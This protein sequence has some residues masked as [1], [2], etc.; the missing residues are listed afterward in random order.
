MKH[1]VPFLALVLVVGYLT[2]I[3]QVSSQT[4]LI[5]KVWT[6]KTEYAVGELVRIYF[7]VNKD[8]YIRLVLIKPGSTPILAEGDVTGGVVYYV[9]GIAGCPVG[10]RTVKLYAWSASEGVVNTTSFRVRY[11]F[12]VEVSV[13]VFKNGLAQFNVV[14]EPQFTSWSTFYEVCYKEYS[15]QLHDDQIDLISGFTGISKNSITVIE[16]NYYSGGFYVKA[17]VDLSLSPY[18]NL[19]MAFYKFINPIAGDNE[20]ILNLFQVYVEEGISKVSPAPSS[21]QTYTV[22]WSGIDAKDANEFII[23]SFITVNVAI[24]GLPA[25]GEVKVVVE[26][27]SGKVAEQYVK[28]GETTVFKLAGGNTYTVKVP[29][30]VIIGDEY[31]LNQHNTKTVST[32]TS[33]VFKY[34]G[35]F[36]RFSIDC[37]YTVEIKVL[38]LKEKL[39]MTWWVVPNQNITVKVPE[40]VDYNNGTRLVFISW[41]DGYNKTFR[42]FYVTGPVKTGVKYVKQYYV[43]INDPVGKQVGITQGEGWYNEGS[44]ATLKVLNNTVYVSSLERYV[45]EE[46]SGDISSDSTKVTAKVDKP[47]TVTVE[48]KHQYKLIVET[49]YSKAILTPYSPDGWYDEGTTV[50]VKIE[51]TS[52]SDTPFTGFVFKEW[53]REDTG[54]TI[55]SAEITVKMD[56]PVKLKAVWERTYNITLIALVVAVA[57]VVPL[58]L[59]IWKRGGLAGI[60]EKVKRVKPPEVKPKV[61]PPTPPPTTP[62][63]EEKL[64][65]PPP[66]REKLP[67]TEQLLPPPPEKLPPPPETTPPPPKEVPPP[68]PKEEKIIQPPPEKLPPP[69]VE[70]KPVAPPPPT[71]IC[72][73]GG[74]D[75]QRGWPPPPSKDGIFS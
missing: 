34:I 74:S 50:T 36:Y 22:S 29:E 12:N 18:S 39:P 49:D 8:A 47:I 37:N 31:Y 75:S 9:E 2:W 46:W 72:A 3:P 1:A 55:E 33:I 66:P 11:A 64:P 23:S 4:P 6:T 51:E 59:F 16:K 32:S 42:W 65:P 58:T 38:S 63:L 43:T 21:L 17:G 67:P 70:V 56:K 48:W 71:N 25:S 20:K 68:P 52:I 15:S 35:P 5:A 26:D 57:V 40:I 28:S 14:Y 13:K 62:P 19:S 30:E 69:P 53:V 73:G 44:I 27:T 60:S 61:K 54:Q 41:I 10:W 45:F 7:T 24:E